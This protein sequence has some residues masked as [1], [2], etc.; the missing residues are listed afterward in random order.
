VLE[1]KFT[2]S[3]QLDKLTRDLQKA[4]SVAPAAARAVVQKGALN[5]KTD[6]RNRVSG[7]K[8]IPA[9]PYSITYDTKETLFGATAE[10]GPDKDKRQGA[11]GNIIEFGGIHSAPIPHMIPA[12]EA[13][14][15]RFE[16]A[17]EAL[18][19]KSLDLG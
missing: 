2:G 14:Q 7:H 11:L 6:A 18:A 3:D 9:Y 17:M 8:H 1:V 5:I 13:E 10:I 16:A 19:L 15:P 12:G 4:I